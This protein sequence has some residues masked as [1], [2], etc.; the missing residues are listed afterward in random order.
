VLHIV[1]WKWHPGHI[2]YTPQRVPYSAEHVN[3]M[4][5]MLGRYA[6]KAR[7]ICV[8]DDPAGVKCKTFPLWNDCSALFN[9]SGVQFP[10]CYRRL[11]LFDPATQR[12]MGIKKGDRIISIDLDTVIVGDISLLLARHESF[13][14]WAVPGKNKARVFNGSMFSFD[15]GAYADVWGDFNA[16]TS[17]SEA[18]SKGF[19]GS[20]QAW[21]SMKM[22]GQAGWTTDDGVYSYTRDILPHGSLPRNARIVIFHGKRKP[23]MEDAQRFDWVRQ[24]YRT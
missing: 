21:I 13:V 22:Q 17:P 16:E 18:A 14:G 5:A 6:E 1:T 3:I 2:G 9:A 8:T 12:A 24:N 20:D 10:S 15:A 23:W 7:V 19:L 11:K 4:S